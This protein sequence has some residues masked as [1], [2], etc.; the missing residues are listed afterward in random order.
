MTGLKI[1]AFSRGWSVSR[2]PSLE[3][4]FSLHRFQPFH[5]VMVMVAW[6]CGANL[7]AVW[8]ALFPTQWAQFLFRS[9]TL[10]FISLFLPLEDFFLARL[11]PSPALPECEFPSP[12]STLPPVCFYASLYIIPPPARSIKLFQILFFNANFGYCICKQLTVQFTRAKYCGFCLRALPLTVRAPVLCVCTS[13]CTAGDAG[14]R[15]QLWARLGARLQARSACASVLIQYH[16]CAFAVV[17]LRWAFIRPSRPR[18]WLN[19]RPLKA[20]TSLLRSLQA[21]VVV[22]RV[23]DF[24]VKGEEYCMTRGF[25]LQLQW[26]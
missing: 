25:V 6:G 17:L 23:K 26:Q 3:C 20:A 8:D 14:A 16:C 22:G 2:S 4:F 24:E 11:F 9:A 1:R 5:I 7:L 13:V 10:G 15:I 18:G 12:S 19:Y 21:E